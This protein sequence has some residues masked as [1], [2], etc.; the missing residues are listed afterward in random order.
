MIKQNIE[1]RRGRREAVFLFAQIF[2]NVRY[3]QS[4]HWLVHCTCLLFDP[5]RTSRAPLTASFRVLVQIAIVRC[6]GLGG[7]N[8]A[9]R[10]RNDCRLRGYVAAD[11][12]RAAA[13]DAG[14]WVS[15]RRIP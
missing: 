3:W 7:D 2:S 13:G 12:S 1:L 8:E 5:K 10:F 11:G 4:G 6:L 14:H 15:Q 9:T